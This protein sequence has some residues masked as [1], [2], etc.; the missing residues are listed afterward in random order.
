MDNARIEA[1]LIRLD[2]GASLFRRLSSAGHPRPIL[3][4]AEAL[5]RSSPARRLP[6]VVAVLREQPSPYLVFVGSMDS[7]VRARLDDLRGLIEEAGERVSVLGWADV[8]AASAQLARSVEDV[9]GPRAGRAPIV[10]V[11]RGGLVVAGL[12]A[13]ALG[14]PAARVG[15]EV[16]LF[17]GRESAPDTPRKPPLP[18]TPG[19]PLLPGV[20]RRPPL[21]DASGQPL[22]LVDD[23]VLTG[24]RLREVLRSLPQDQRVVV[25][26][27]ASHPRLRENVLSSEPQVEAFVSALDL[28]DHAP[29]LLGD[30]AQSWRDMW[31]ERAPDRYH[32]ALLDMVVFPWSEP[33]L[34]LWNE[35][36]GEM[37]EGWRITPPELCF[38][39]RHTPP[40]IPLQRVDE[41]P[42]MERLGP[43][44]IPVELTD[45]TLVLSVG[46]RGPA[47]DLPSFTLRGTARQIWH[48]WLEGGRESAVEGMRARYPQVDRDRIVGD[49]DTLLA[50][51]TEA[52]IARPGV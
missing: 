24:L 49:V 10:P 26:V 20:P 29:R 37:E 32:T 31:S 36:T 35:A 50:Q 41:G 28:E 15:A 40:G 18:K 38:R 45:R 12:L 43:D 14:A 5:I 16:A 48:L 47:G 33:P 8:E 27:L 30:R 39:T 13:Y 42:G 6:G 2:P 52:G 34:R 11:P 44:V 7:A 22:L 17:R 4:L 21:S 3:G 46:D 25:A 19:Q 9:L 23:V 51:L 1:Y